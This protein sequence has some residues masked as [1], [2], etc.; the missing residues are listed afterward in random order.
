MPETLS[1]TSDTQ[2]T[3]FLAR[4]RVLLTAEREADLA[5]TSLLLSNCGPKLLQQQGLALLGLG[6]S[7][8]NVGLGGKTLIE[9]DRPSAYH[10]SP[11]FPPHSLRPGDLARIEE[12]V[13]GKPGR[14]KSSAKSTSTSEVN[15]SGGS[16]EGVV[17]KVSSRSRYLSMGFL[18]DL[19]LRNKDCG[20]G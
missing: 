3:T 20:C 19:G 11:E 10:T 12:N 15:S 9:L 8:I 6:V 13:T 2:F 18:Q 5:R 1:K 7:S 16:V 17:Y 4:H 14:A